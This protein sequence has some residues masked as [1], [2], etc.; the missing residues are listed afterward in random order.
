MD[1][2]NKITILWTG[3]G[4]LIFI[5]LYNSYQTPKPEEDNEDDG[6]NG[7]N[8]GG[9][10]DKV[11]LEIDVSGPGYLDVTIDSDEKGSIKNNSFI[12]DY[13]SYVLVEPVP[14]AGARL[15]NVSDSG[16]SIQNDTTVTATFEK[17]GGNGENGNETGNPYN[18][19]NDQWSVC[20]SG[21]KD[22]LERKDTCIWTPTFPFIVCHK[23]VVFGFEGWF[24][25]IGLR[26]QDYSSN[27]SFAQAV[28]DIIKLG[29]PSPIINIHFMGPGNLAETGSKQDIIDRINKSK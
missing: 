24:N 5:A 22:L 15:I 11:T 27:E 28:A 17:T 8:G 29:A 3:V 23:P 9:Q 20:S 12:V 16:F 1:S 7:E 4:L 21:V 19:S 2:E 26:Q 6:E 10:P 13:G 14:E 18:L 25:D